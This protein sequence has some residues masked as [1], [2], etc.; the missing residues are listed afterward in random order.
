MISAFQLSRLYDQ[1]EALEQI[2]SNIPVE[3]LEKQIRSGKWSIKENIAHLVRYQKESTDRVNRILTEANPSLRRYIAEE[4][5]GF[6][7][8]ASLP[9]ESLRKQLKSDRIQFNDMVKSFTDD[10]LSR[11]G[12]HPVFG[13]M[14]LTEW[15]EFFLLH[16]A[17]HMMTIFQLSH[18]SK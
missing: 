17:H 13:M 4:D 9:P 6:P 18:S 5:E 1:P 14:T 3:L 7:L 16:E 10:Q 2:L 11:T 15:I 8:I 12:V